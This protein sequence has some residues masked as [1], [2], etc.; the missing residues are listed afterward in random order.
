MD[1]AKSRIMAAALELFSSK[2]YRAVSTREIA[3]AASVN[4]VTIFR[5]FGN[6]AALFESVHAEHFVKPAIVLGEV[7]MGADL[8][9]DLA[10]LAVAY[11]VLFQKNHKLVAMSVK[12]IKAEFAEIHEELKGQVPALTRFVE[13]RIRSERRSEFE[14]GPAAAGR[15]GQ[16]GEMEAA[17]EDAE[18]ARL[19]RMFAGCIGG[20]ALHRALSDSLEGLSSEAEV[21]AA[22]LAKGIAERIRA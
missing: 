16:K 6:K 19:A 5:I 4:E 14:S 9:A 12:D 1:C 21:A 8:E 13:L 10:A 11:V 3:K 20:L 7:P 15:E 18:P 2:G 22:M 17:G